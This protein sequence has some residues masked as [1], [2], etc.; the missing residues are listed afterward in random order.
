MFPDRA[1]D[2]DD[3]APF[4]DDVLPACR[5]LPEAELVLD[6]LQQLGI[7]AVH[8]REL[9]EFAPPLQIRQ[10]RARGPRTGTDHPETKLRHRPCAPFC[11]DSA[12]A[13]ATR[14]AR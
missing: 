3:V 2:D 1:A 14:R 12:E 9:H 11:L 7:P 8:D 4:G 5:R 6:L 13:E 10:V